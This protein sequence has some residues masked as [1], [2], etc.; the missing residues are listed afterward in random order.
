M[1]DT[2]HVKPGHISSKKLQ[3]RLDKFFKSDRPKHIMAMRAYIGLDFIEIER[4][5]TIN[6]RYYAA[7]TEAE[8]V[9][10]NMAVDHGFENDKG[11]ARWF[12]DRYHTPLKKPE[13][14]KDEG[15][16]EGVRIVIVRDEKDA[17]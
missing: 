12:L 17:K 13:E 8:M 14:L 5:K 2:L 3:K 15:P 11:F 4:L 16:G 9:C 7:L 10:E 6:D 1:A